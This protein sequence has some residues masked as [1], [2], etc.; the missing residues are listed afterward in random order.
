MIIHVGVGKTGPLRVETLGH[1]VGYKHGDA[2]DDLAPEVPLVS[3]TIVTTGGDTNTERI[4]DD[5]IQIEYDPSVANQELLEDGKLR[6]FGEGY[7]AFDLEERTIANVPDIVEWL[8]QKGMVSLNCL[9]YNYFLLI[10]ERCK[11]LPG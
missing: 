5:Q 11:N 1:K 7:E 2:R 6:G 8:K 4:A 3:R 10:L 9:A